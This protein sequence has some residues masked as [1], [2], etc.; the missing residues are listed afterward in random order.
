MRKALDSVNWERLFDKKDLN[1]KVKALNKAILN[2]FWNYVP[3]EY[4]TVDNKDPDKKQTLQAI[5]TEWKV[6]K[7]IC[8]Y[9]KI[10]NWN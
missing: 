1:A 9:C 5:Y 6:W 8:A 2:V 3:N 10:S 7:W 4:I